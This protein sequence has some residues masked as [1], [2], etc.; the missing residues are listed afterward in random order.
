[1][2]TRETHHDRQLKAE[3][4]MLRR[5]LQKRRKSETNEV[6][7]RPCP[8][9]GGVHWKYKVL[10]DEHIA[11]CGSAYTESLTQADTDR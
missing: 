7:R 4:L 6:D 1:M 10:R 5:R 2:T 8:H 3:R 11:K 9:C